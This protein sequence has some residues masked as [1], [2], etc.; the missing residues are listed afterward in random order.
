MISYKHCGFPF[1]SHLSHFTKLNATTHI[2]GFLYSI[3]F[4][5]RISSDNKSLSIVVSMCHG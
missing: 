4:P 5:F 2:K 1:F 3:I